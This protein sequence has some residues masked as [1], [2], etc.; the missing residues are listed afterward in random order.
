[1]LPT[2]S[3]IPK[4]VDAQNFLVP[5]DSRNDADHPE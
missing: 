4:S 1:M 2:V 3:K 5:I